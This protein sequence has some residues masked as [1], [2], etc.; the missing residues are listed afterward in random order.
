MF[1]L[2]FVLGFAAACLVIFM[3]AYVPEGFDVVED[4]EER[5]PR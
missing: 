1:T 2:G 3:I 5:T 4:P